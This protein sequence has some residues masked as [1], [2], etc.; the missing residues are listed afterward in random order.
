MDSLNFT[1]DGNLGLP[2]F[3]RMPPPFGT[4]RD[5]V[6][7]IQSALRRMQDGERL[8]MGDAE[9]HAQRVQLRQRLTVIAIG[10]ACTVAVALIGAHT[11]KRSQPPFHID[12][13][14]HAAITQAPVPNVLPEVA[15]DDAEPASATRDSLETATAHAAKAAPQVR[16]API[17]STLP[18]RP[19]KPNA[20]ARA[21]VRAA[22]PVTSGYVAPGTSVRIKRLRHTRLTDRRISPHHPRRAAAA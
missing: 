21:R 16:Q 9:R 13:A 4:R 17:V 8:A 11:S 22:A 18:D 7:I 15:A 20:L 2:G 5:A 12:P 6:R 3:V 14:P 10:V 1:I 19:A